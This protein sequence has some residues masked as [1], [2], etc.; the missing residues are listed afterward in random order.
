MTDFVA[1]IRK[2][3]RF[4]VGNQNKDGSWGTAALKGGVEIYAD[5][6]GGH[7][8]FRSAVTALNVFMPV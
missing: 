7:Q 6:P 2:G 3:V 4:L 1:A 5:V 8:A